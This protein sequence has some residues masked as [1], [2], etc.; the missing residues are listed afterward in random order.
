M[1]LE[2]LLNTYTAKTEQQLSIA[3]VRH[4]EGT[5]EKTILKDQQDLGDKSPN[6]AIPAA[7]A[8]LEMKTP[9]ASQHHPSGRIR[10]KGVPNTMPSP[11]ETTATKGISNSP[12]NSSRSSIST[13]SAST[14]TRFRSESEESDGGLVSA[15]LIT[16][17]GLGT[18]WR[19][20]EKLEAL[21][22]ATLLS[23]ECLSFLN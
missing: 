18:I 15:F 16:D 1:F 9:G 3:K 13:K 10:R 14:T 6:P 11:M 21:E 22:K 23:L 19:E 20:P 7:L 17:L 2:D 5:E 4:M 12:T 8:L